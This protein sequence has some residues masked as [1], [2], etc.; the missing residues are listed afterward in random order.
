MY[1]FTSKFLN[2]EIVERITRIKRK[3][4]DKSEFITDEYN[5]LND[6]KSE[7]ISYFTKDHV[8]SLK[9]NS[10]FT[11]YFD[12]IL[13]VHKENVMR[14]IDNGDK[15]SHYCPCLFKIIEEKL[16]ILPLWCGI[17]LSFEQLQYFENIDSRISNNPVENYFNT[18]RNS[19]LRINKKQKMIRRLMPSQAISRLVKYL[20]F[21]YHEIYEDKFNEFYPENNDFK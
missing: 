15:N 19:I 10:P 7:I 21:K 8:E 5:Q 3:I 16:Y 14:E 18:L 2:E 6:P 13:K 11:K 4:N 9:K 17:L 1:I 20:V 12:R